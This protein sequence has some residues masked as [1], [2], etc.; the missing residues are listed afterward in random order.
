MIA[1]IANGSSAKEFVMRDEI[2]LKRLMHYMMNDSVKLQMAAT[3][4]VSN[5]V[6]STEEGAVDRQ[7]KL[8]DL[9]VQKLLQ[10]L[11]TTSDVNLF[12][13][14][15]RDFL[16]EGLTVKVPQELNLG[17]QESPIWDLFQVKPRMVNGE[18][19]PLPLASFADQN[20]SVGTL[21]PIQNSCEIFFG[22]YFIIISWERIVQFRVFVFE[23]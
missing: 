6:W 11:L 8:R 2:L 1:N 7:Q 20:Q 15:G 10:S 17:L 18:R 16:S 23:N 3:Y 5:L 9:G 22:E 13:R 4:C 12:E 19:M 21:W 14:Y